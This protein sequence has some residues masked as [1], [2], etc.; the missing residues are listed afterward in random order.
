MPTDAAAVKADPKLRLVMSDSLGYVGITNN[1]AN[2]KRADNPYG[3]SALVRQ[4]FSLAIDRPALVNV[5]YQ[6][7][8]CAD[9]AGGPGQFA[10]LRR[11]PEVPARDV[12]KAKALLAQAGVKTPVPLELMV[13]NNP[14]ADR[15]P[16]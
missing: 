10:V 3:Q 6:R 15:R 8:V 16:R 9:D 14:D 7:H 1:L 13:A 12:A 4:A 11:R 2:G 5:V